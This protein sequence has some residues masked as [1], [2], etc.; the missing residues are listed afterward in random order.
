MTMTSQRLES[1][2]KYLLDMGIDRNRLKT[3]AFG[4]TQPR[5]QNNTEEN[6]K[7]NRR[8]EFGFYASDALK[9]EAE[10]MTQ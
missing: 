6:R 3:K 9:N 1:I 7:R 5:Y 4:E 10:A 2:K 8:I